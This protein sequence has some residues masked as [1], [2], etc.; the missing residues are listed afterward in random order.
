MDRHWCAHS[1]WMFFRTEH[2]HVSVL[3]IFCTVSHAIVIVAAYIFSVRPSVNGDWRYPPL[4]DKAFCG[5]MTGLS[6]SLAIL[7][8]HLFSVHWE[9]ARAS[10]FFSSTGRLGDTSW[11]TGWP[12]NKRNA[13]RICSIW[14]ER[15]LRVIKSP[16]SLGTVEVVSEINSK[17]R[18]TLTLCSCTQ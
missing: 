17:L 14:K 7:P 1:F 9:G 16:L 18:L 10:P 4:L 5:W 11:W 15:P 12:W 8:S 2:F 13:P 6:S 3:L